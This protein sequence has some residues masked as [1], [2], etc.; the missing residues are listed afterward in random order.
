MNSFILKI[1]DKRNE[2]T[3]EKELMATT[4]GIPN[5]VPLLMCFWRFGNPFTSNSRF[6]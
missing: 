3:Y 1:V 4:T 5:F 2:S 6:S